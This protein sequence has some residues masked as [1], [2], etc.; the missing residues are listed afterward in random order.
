M[1]R[2]I[3]IL[4]L[5]F[6]VSINS[7]AGKDFVAH[8]NAVSGSYNFWFYDPEE[9]HDP[10]AH[11]PLLIFLHGKS[12]CGTNMDRVK[13]Y[14]P[15]HAVAKGQYIDSYIMAPQN[16]GGAWNPEKLWKIVEWAKEHYSID[17][18]RIYVFGMSLG[19]YGTID[20]AAAYPD[21]IASAMAI[22]GGAST[23]NLE[24]LSNIPL[25][26]IHGTADRAVPIA[27]S[28]KVVE[29]I[30]KNGDSSRLLYTRL[31]GVDHGRPARIFYMNQTYDWLFSHCLN[32]E[33]RP[34][35]R[36]FEYTPE[37]LNTAYQD[38]GKGEPIDEDSYK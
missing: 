32:D 33:G 16:P 6:T 34:V 22:C 27:Q 17:E 11:F 4:A 3:Y 37:L 14:G 20:F 7:F 13:R 19:G 36:D 10:R 2:F 24:G 38:L 26:I 5:L 1:L 9:T 23:R 30:R 25:W 35:N 18:S 12:L 15:I 8:R 31:K 21:K 29:A 28:D